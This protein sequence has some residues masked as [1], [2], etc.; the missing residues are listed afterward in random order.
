MARVLVALFSRLSCLAMIFSTLLD[1]QDAA[2]RSSLAD[3]AIPSFLGPMADRAGLCRG[4][5]NGDGEAVSKDL[6]KL[7]VQYPLMPIHQSDW[8]S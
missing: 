3:A 8:L 6:F 7:S 5:A 4:V 1:L 2:L